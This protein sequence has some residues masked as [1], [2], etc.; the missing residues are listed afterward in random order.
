MQEFED[1]YDDADFSDDGLS[2]KDIDRELNQHT[3]SFR[4]DENWLEFE[5]MFFDDVNGDDY[6]TA[7]FSY[8]TLDFAGGETSI[9]DNFRKEA[10]YDYLVKKDCLIHDNK[11]EGGY[12]T[13]FLSEE[14]V[15]IIVENNY[16]AS[17]IQVVS[18]DS[19]HDLEY[20]VKNSLFHMISD[21]MPLL[22]ESYSSYDTL[23]RKID[24]FKLDNF[25]TD[26][27]E[28][29]RFMDDSLPFRHIC[30]RECDDEYFQGR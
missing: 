6:E 19:S 29:E 21:V 1:N 16:Y 30:E 28:D 9:L 2:M 3:A 12:F 15:D 22:R 7:P 24:N 25:L 17:K 8:I 27:L 13:S 20:N 18:H 4:L 14:G 11:A 26:K 5:A 10:I 23:K